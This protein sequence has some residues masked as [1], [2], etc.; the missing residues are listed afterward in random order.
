MPDPSSIPMGRLVVKEVSDPITGEVKLAVRSVAEKYDEEVRDRIAGEY[1]KHGRIGAASRA[2]NVTTSTVK[3]WLQ[4]RQD[5]AVA[6]AEA[7]EAY[8]DKLIE[9][10]QNLVFNGTVKET[11]DRQGRLVGKETIYPIRL[12]ELELKKHDEGYR[13]KREVDMNVRGGVMI[14]PAETKSVDD[15][16]AR[17]GPQSRDA[18]DAEVVDDDGKTD[19]L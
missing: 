18:E 6:M 8:R 17:F 14:A 3:R 2:G 16:E 13:D 9:H 19:D 7:N 5:F 15:W 11:Y 12:I 10:H 1:A 4:E